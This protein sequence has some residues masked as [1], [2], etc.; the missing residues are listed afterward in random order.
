[1]V[2][3]IENSR[4]RAVLD[5]VVARLE[6]VEQRTI[7]TREEMRE[8]SDT[9]GAAARTLGMRGLKYG[10]IIT[11]AAVSPKDALA[12]LLNYVEEAERSDEQDPADLPDDPD[13]T[14]FDE[15]DAA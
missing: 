4:I 15:D 12:R 11:L 7:Q 3:T 6:R 14:A 2:Q 5:P 9:I 10:L 13:A 8:L 1:M